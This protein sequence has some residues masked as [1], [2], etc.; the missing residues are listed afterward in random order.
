MDEPFCTLSLD[1]SQ[2]PPGQALLL[3]QQIGVD[4]LGSEDKWKV[5]EI[6]AGEDVEFEGDIELHLDTGRAL[7]LLDDAEIIDVQPDVVDE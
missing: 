3:A 7:T 5:G 6:M 1:L 4:R 2:L